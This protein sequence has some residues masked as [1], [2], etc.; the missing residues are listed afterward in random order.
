MDELSWL[1][2]DNDVAQWPVGLRADVDQDEGSR[3]SRL[4]SS[5]LDELRQL[6]G[7][8]ERDEARQDEINHHSTTDGFE[9]S[10]SMK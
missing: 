2:S 8:V 4:L 9:E 10:E 5:I 3:T 1:I 7:K 6:T